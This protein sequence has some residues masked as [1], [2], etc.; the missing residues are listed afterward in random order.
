VKDRRGDT[1]D[2]VFLMLSVR[3]TCTNCNIMLICTC[4]HSHRIN[5]SSNVGIC[6]KCVAPRN[7][8]G[9]VC[10]PAPVWRRDS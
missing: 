5:I 1:E 7:A 10:A 9:I 6:N 8:D 4:D 2:D 3:M